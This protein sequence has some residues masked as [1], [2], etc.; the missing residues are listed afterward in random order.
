MKDLLLSSVVSLLSLL[1]SAWCVL[2][3]PTRR[4][5]ACRHVCAN[6]YLCQV[7][8]VEYMDYLMTWVEGQISNEAIF[9][10]LAGAFTYLTHTH[11]HTRTHTW[12]AR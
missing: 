4:A 10:V 11:T 9:P 12:K 5:Y 7:S 1:P 2:C 8:A 3:M 6:T